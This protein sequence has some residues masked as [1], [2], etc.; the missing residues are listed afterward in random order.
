MSGT[1]KVMGAE[2]LFPQKGLPKSPPKLPK[3][4][5]RRRVIRCEKCR[6]YLFDVDLL[7]CNPGT[8]ACVLIML[9]CRNSK[10]RKPNQVTIDLVN[11]DPPEENG[12]EIHR[13]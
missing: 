7:R 1:A 8:Q 12:K 6:S 13:A 9:R 11:E 5:G 2:E 3:T 4:Q 10:C